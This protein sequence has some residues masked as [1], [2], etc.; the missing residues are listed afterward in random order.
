M[1]VFS[2]VIMAGLSFLIGF[3]AQRSRMCF[4]AGLRDF[5]LVRDGE[6]LKGLFAFIATIWLLSSVLYGTG[7]ITEGVP[8]P[9]FDED[10]KAA[11]ESNENKIEKPS[12]NLIGPDAEFAAEQFAFEVQQKIFGTGIIASPFMWASVI[13]GFLLG[14]LTTAAGGCVLR[15]HVLAAQ[16]QAD[17][18]FFIAG[19]FIMIIIYDLFLRGIV[20]E[21]F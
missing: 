18:K 3:L 9:L 15:Q 14:L 19:F 5:I 8:A 12:E 17:A 4:I 21:W 16:G 13:G 1:R 6:L 2:T 10:N 11:I 7:I 20:S